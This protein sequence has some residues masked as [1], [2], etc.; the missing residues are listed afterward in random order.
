MPLQS[1]SSHGSFVPSL[2]LVVLLKQL[3][4]RIKMMQILSLPFSAQ[5]TV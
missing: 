3:G 4:V 5:S 2:S 1:H